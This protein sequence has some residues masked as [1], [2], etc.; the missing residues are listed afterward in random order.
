[1]TTNHKPLN[2]KAIN[3]L[4]K[5]ADVE[6]A[7]IF[8]LNQYPQISQALTDYLDL[9]ATM[10]KHLG[11]MGCGVAVKYLDELRAMVPDDE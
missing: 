4:L 6:N 5:T 2:K 11:K 10:N 7:L 3:A 1:M 8:K 9:L